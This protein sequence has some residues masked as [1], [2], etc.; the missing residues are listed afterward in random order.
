MAH[1][2]QDKNRRNVT[3]TTS[4]VG[5][6]VPE[7]F[8]EENSKL[9][10]F[11]QNY[12]DHLDS[13]Q[14]Q[15]F[16]HKIKQLIYARDADQAGTDELDSLIEEIG[17]GLKSASFFQKPRLMT[18]LLG[19][20]YR[21]KGSLNSAEGFFRGFFG[22]EPEISY[23]KKDIFKIGSSEIGYDSQKFITNAGIYQVFSILIK[24]GISTVDYLTLYKRFVHPAGFHFSGE[25]LAVEE[26]SLDVE[27]TASDGI[28]TGI[29]AWG[30]D[31]LETDSVGPTAI[32]QA[33]VT[34]LTGVRSDGS[35][36]ADVAP[37]VPFREL[38]IF[39]DS[40]G[41]KLY[42]SGDAYRVDPYGIK[43]SDISSFTTTQ[44][45]NWYAH[46][47]EIFHPN[48][49]TFDD[50]TDSNRPDFSMTLETMDDEIFTTYLSDSSY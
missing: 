21:A 50:E 10:E 7:Y 19:D 20:Y 22:L 23:P 37:T 8:G 31:P 34:D 2:T 5:E 13:D 24:C 36:F 43:I 49:F 45:Q 26:G 17:N 39:I 46:I 35:F 25:V 41:R 32:S 42:D 4:K 27:L 47:W 3:L 15:G 29:E 1:S 48:S 28:H 12:H 38:T 14:A 16:G 6:V 9:I 11:L 18:K 33:L 30:S 44:L 40:G